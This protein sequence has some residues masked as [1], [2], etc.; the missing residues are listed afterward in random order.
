MPS[1]NCSDAFHNG[2]IDPKYYRKIMKRSDQDIETSINTKEPHV[3][4]EESA[5]R[6]SSATQEGT[7]R[8]N[9][10]SKSALV[11]KAF[12]RNLELKQ[13]LKVGRQ[14]HKNLHRKKLLKAMNVCG[15]P[16]WSQVVNSAGYVCEMRSVWKLDAPGNRL[17]IWAK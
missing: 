3:E 9:N 5:T 10:S 8:D 2:Q 6:S 17:L 16:G 7:E 13:D 4:I 15:N 14:R 1:I 12:R 11:K